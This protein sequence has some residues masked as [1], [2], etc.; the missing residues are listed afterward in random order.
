MEAAFIRKILCFEVFKYFSVN[1]LTG[2]LKIKAFMKAKPP[3]HILLLFSMKVDGGYTH[4]R[5]EKSLGLSC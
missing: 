1:W 2:C 3:Y 4:S 5:R